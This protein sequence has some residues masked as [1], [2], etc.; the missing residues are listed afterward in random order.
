MPR[1]PKRPDSVP[2]IKTYKNRLTG[3][4]VTKTKVIGEGGR[5]EKTTTKVGENKTTVRKKTKYPTGY[6]T[7]ET[8]TTRTPDMTQRGVPKRPDFISETVTRRKEKGLPPDLP[9]Q[10]GKGTPPGWHAPMKLPETKTN[11]QYKDLTGRTM[12]T[13][14]GK[15]RRKAKETIKEGKYT[16]GRN[17]DARI[18]NKENLAGYKRTQAERVQQGF[19]EYNRKISDIRKLRTEDP[20][21]RTMTTYYKKGGQKEMIKRADGSYSQRGLWDNIRA[22]KGS[23]KKPTKQMLKQERKIK[24]KSK[25]K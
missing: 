8:T 16:Y 1:P 9:T 18:K 19:D 2:R 4:T 22:N 20:M 13:T 3:D 7:K 15:Y 5:K 17:I 10:L 21:Q 25:T 11:V 12:N 23:G 24:A 14:A 6:K